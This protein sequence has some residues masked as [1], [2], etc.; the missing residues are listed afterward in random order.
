MRITSTKY[1]KE[2]FQKAE[3][4]FCRLKEQKE[5]LEKVNLNYKKEERKKK[6]EEPKSLPTDNTSKE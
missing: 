1:I 2:K 5:F 4:Q 6:Q 3:R